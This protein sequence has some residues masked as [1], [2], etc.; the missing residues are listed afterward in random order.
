MAVEVGS[1]VTWIEYPPEQGRRITRTIVAREQFVRHASRDN[2]QAYEMYMPEDAPI[3]MA[4]IGLNV[5][6]E[7]D[8]DTGVGTKR[9]VIRRI[10][11]S[12]R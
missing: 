8:L 6:E 10:D 5:G 3:A 1:L 12:W 7:F 9:G 11:Q 4:M 2:R